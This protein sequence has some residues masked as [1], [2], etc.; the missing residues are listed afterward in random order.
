MTPN[1]GGG[2]TWAA[3]E[4]TALTGLATL[5]LRRL[6]LEMSNE[7]GATAT[8]IQFRLEVSGAL[9]TA[10]P[11]TCAAAT[12]VTLPTAD[13]EIVDSTNFTDGDQTS[14]ITPG[15]SDANTTF[16]PGQ[17]KDAGNQ[18]TGITLTSADFTEIEFALRAKA[19]ATPGA[20]YCFRLTNAGSTTDFTDPYPQYAQATI[21]GVDNFSVEAAGGGAIGTQDED[22]AFNIQVTA[23][24]YLNT[25]VTSFTGTVEITSTGT[26]SNG[27]GTTA[28]FSSGVLSSHSVT[29]ANPGNFTITATSAPA[30]GTSNT[31]TVNAL[32][33]FGFRKAITI[34]RTKVP[35][36]CGTTLP[37]F[38]LLFSVTHLDLSTASGEVTDA[39]GDDILFRALDDA[40][41]GGAGLAPCT[42]DHEIE[43]W[44]MPS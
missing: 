38:P 30:A 7:G 13:W 24:D 27:G 14:N 12:Y 10:S 34:D 43:S 18:T 20:L 36:G 32:A 21:A 3:A 17:L 29:I 26:L 4:D 35:T 6:R 8:G 19:T 11:G 5:T 25:T 22:V 39:Q 16:V 44:V 41:C 37:N 28:S 9:N 23:R 31:F 15:L 1:T 33:P 42:L 2:A 40:T